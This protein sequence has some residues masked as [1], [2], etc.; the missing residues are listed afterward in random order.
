MSTVNNNM[1][2][3]TSS[4]AS[5]A[6]GSSNSGSAATDSADA[7]EDRFLKLLVA[8][9]RNQDPMNPLDNAQVT[10]QLAQISTVR[11]IEQ[12]NQS[13]GGLTSKLSDSSPAS[14]VGMLGRQV[15]VAGSKFDWGGASAA[16]D[17][18]PV[19]DTQTPDVSASSSQPSSVRLGFEL[20]SEAKVLRVEIVD[21]AGQVVSTRDLSNVAS[22]VQTFEWD[23]KRSDG[24]A[25]PAGSYQLRVYGAAADGGEVAVSPLVM[26]RVLGI[27]QGSDGARLE[28]SNGSS[29]AA[30]GVKA[31]V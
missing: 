16:D 26:A 18:T 24:S 31:I 15:M 9:M 17:T 5:A 1:S 22:G 21:S 23:G 10:S 2:Q 11:G 12:L 29:A 14:A 6:N 7:T 27:T 25:A 30:S 8:Q 13:M 20:V 28:L 3:Y 19:D 4:A